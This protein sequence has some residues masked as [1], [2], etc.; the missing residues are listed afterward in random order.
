MNEAIQTIL[1]WTYPILLLVFI[2]LAALKKSMPGKIWFLLYLGI[3]L[4]VNLAWMTPLLLSKV[5]VIKFSQYS[6]L[7]AFCGIPLQIIGLIGLCM[8]FPFI[9]IDSNSTRAPLGYGSKEPASNRQWFYQENG[10]Q[11]GPIT[12]RDLQHMIL[13]GR[14][15][16]H[17]MVWTDGMPAWQEA[18][19]CGVAPI[20]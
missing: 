5:G 10:V 20:R 9:L 8:L 7:M 3:G 19:A 15:H 18:S 17:T 6:H 11:R 2:V 13:V 4:C 14:L 16:A 12:E 1:Q